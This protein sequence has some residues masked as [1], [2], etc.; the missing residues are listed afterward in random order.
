MYCREEKRRNLYLKSAFYVKSIF[1][2]STSLNTNTLN[3]TSRTSMTK[4]LTNYVHLKFLQ[5]LKVWLS[6]CILTLLRKNSVKSTLNR[7]KM[8]IRWFDE[9]IFCEI[10]LYEIVI[11]FSLFNYKVPHIIL[12]IFLYFYVNQFHEIF[13]KILI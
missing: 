13:L 3:S 9:I 6:I 1:G 7:N 11:M 8:L 2:K 5:I 12:K 10:T 4:F